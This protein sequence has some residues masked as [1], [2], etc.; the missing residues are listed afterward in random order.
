FAFGRAGPERDERLPGV[1]RDADV[2]I[3]L[4][5]DPV[6]DRK[7]SANRALGVVLVRKRSAEERDDG[8]AD[9]LLHRAA[10][11]LELRAHA[12]VV[13]GEPGAHVLGIHPLGG[14]R[15]ADEVAEHDRDDLP[16]LARRLRLAQAGAAAR[17]EAEILGALVAATRANRH[18]KS[19][20]AGS[21]ESD[22]AS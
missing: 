3:G 16:L 10:E 8:V 5:R 11:A 1:D 6:A 22:R 17:T 21:G 14:R 4:L 2:K 12:R 20:R 19:V 9:E 15:R 18:G 13:A 7:R